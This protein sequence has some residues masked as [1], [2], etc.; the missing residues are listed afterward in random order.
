MHSC[1]ALLA[2]CYRSEKIS[3]DTQWARQK[4]QVM[5]VP[6]VPWL[7]IAKLV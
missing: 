4:I 3:F 5:Q 6:L 7:F 1:E 2:V